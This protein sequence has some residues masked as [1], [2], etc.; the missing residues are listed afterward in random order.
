MRVARPIVLSP[1]SR[2]QFE[3]QVRGR[4]V[5]VRL[6]LRSRIVLLA[7]EGKQHKQISVELKISPRRHSDQKRPRR[8]PQPTRLTGPR[9][10]WRVKLASARPSVRRIWHAHGL[11]P[12]LLKTFK[13]SC[14]PEFAY[15]LE[16]IVGLYLNPRMRW[17]CASMR[18]A[19]YRPGIDP[20]LD[21]R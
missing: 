17:F 6:A 20:S 3:R 5:P 14:D 1:E 8:P 7:A 13:I 18:R 16:A 21:C 4:T 9:A 19:R 15:K 10:P 2:N 12:H 11:K